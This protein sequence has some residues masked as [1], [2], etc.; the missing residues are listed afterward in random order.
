MCRPWCPIGTG[1]G[2]GFVFTNPVAGEPDELGVGP[3]GFVL[4]I[5]LARVWTA[6]VIAAAAGIGFVFAN[7]LAGGPGGLGVGR[8]GFEL[9]NPLARRWLAWLSLGLAS[10]SQI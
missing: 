4:V 6:P 10:Y 1:A 3:I 5:P 9:V 7:P 8:I 2:I